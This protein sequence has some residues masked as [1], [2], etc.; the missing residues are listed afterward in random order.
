VILLFD[1]SN[2]MRRVVARVAEAAHAAMGELRAGDRVCIMTFDRTFDLIQE[3]NADLGVAQ[4]VSSREQS[5][6]RRA[7]ITIT[8]DQGASVHPASLRDLE[9]SDAVLLGVVV[10]HRG[11]PRPRYQGIRDFAIQTGGDM[12]NTQ[13][14]GEGL[15]ETL[16]RLR[17]RYSLYYA[18]PPCK[19]GEER[20]V[21]VGI[22]GRRRGPAPG[23][24]RAS[25][26]RLH[27]AAL[28]CKNASG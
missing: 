4:H 18:L 15:R 7:I 21:Q 19:P 23:S 13:D 28:N 11:P 27:R 24:H 3:F 16:N 12:L 10:K 20:K 9:E 14:A 25:A 2:S 17:R 26:D 6:R 22:D 1:T 5:Y 8:D